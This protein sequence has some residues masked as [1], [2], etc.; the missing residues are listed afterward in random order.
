M[1]VIEVRD[2]ATTHQHAAHEA[3]TQAQD[4][5]ALVGELTRRLAEAGL[6]TSGADGEEVGPIGRVVSR[7]ETGATGPQAPGGAKVQAQ[8]KTPRRAGAQADGKPGPSVRMQHAV[9]YKVCRP[10]RW[11]WPKP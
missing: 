7:A 8:S 2:E 6:P 11:P 4:A 9:Q 1:K 3:L 10:V 5:Q